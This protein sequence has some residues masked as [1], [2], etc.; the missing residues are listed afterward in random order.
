MMLVTKYSTD[1]VVIQCK[2][3]QILMFWLDPSESLVLPACFVN[4][5]ADP[6]LL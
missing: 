5:G 6:Y 2:I 4:E 3:T 1:N